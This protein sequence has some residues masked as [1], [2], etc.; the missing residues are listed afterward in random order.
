MQGLKPMR[1]RAGLT[2][3]GLAEVL[4]VHPLTVTRWELGTMHPRAEML[5]RIA[6]KLLCEVSDL[7]R[8]VAA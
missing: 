3:S 4:G 2:Q 6:A 8:G 1:K 5:K 7:F